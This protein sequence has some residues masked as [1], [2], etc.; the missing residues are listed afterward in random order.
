VRVRA[1][2]G[3]GVP[4]ARF[5]LRGIRYDRYFRYAAALIIASRCMQLA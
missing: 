2:S 4:L 1:E 3:L 5:T